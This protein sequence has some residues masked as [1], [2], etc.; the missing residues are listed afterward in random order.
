MWNTGFQIPEASE[1]D[2]RTYEIAERILAEMQAET[3]ALNARATAAA[4]LPETEAAAD[5][6]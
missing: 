1:E 3:E 4:A 2:R 5:E 6:D